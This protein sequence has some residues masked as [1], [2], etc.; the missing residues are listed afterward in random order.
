MPQAVDLAS[1]LRR[2]MGISLL[3]LS[4]PCTSPQAFPIFMKDGTTHPVLKLKQKLFSP[5]QHPIT[6]LVLLAE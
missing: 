2:L 4:K 3:V 5:C 6:R 1:P